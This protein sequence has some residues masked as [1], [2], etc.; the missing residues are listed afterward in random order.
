MGSSSF[1]LDMPF[2]HNSRCLAFPLPKRAFLTWRDEKGVTLLELMVVIMIILGMM[3]LVAPTVSSMLGGRGIAKGI[4]DVTGLLELARSEAISKRTRVWVLFKNGTSADNGPEL[5]V[6]AVMALNGRNDWSPSNIKPITRAIKIPGIKCVKFSEM[7]TAVQSTATASGEV[8]LADNDNYVS[9]WGR[10]GFPDF[11][12]SGKTFKDASVFSFVP[13]GEINVSPSIDSFDLMFNP[14]VCVGLAP[15][16]GGALRA[17][18]S[19][20]AIITF[21]GGGTK[22]RIT[23]P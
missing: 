1:A 12:I 10:S 5:W 3:S 4:D 23:R 18:A 11:M 14:Q 20:G 8:C 7:P 15:I 2:F 17:D 22:P 9:E 19:D 16:K 21:Y 6:A 13:T